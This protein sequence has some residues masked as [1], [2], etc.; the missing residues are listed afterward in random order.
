APVSCRD[1][2][3]S[4]VDVGALCLS[5]VGNHDPFE[6][7]IPRTNRGATRT[8][9]RPPPFPASTPCPYRSAGRGRFLVFPLSVG[10]IHSGRDQSA[11]TASPLRLCSTVG[12]LPTNP[13]ASTSTRRYALPRQ[14]QQCI[15][16]RGTDRKAT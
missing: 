10:T 14:E 1:K 4:G 8:G 2:G 16:C 3:R 7:H 5:W 6:D 13:L 12:P 9:T 11:L 15:R